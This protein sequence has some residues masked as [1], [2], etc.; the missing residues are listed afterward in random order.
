MRD[1]VLLVARAAT[2]RARQI[3]AVVLVF[4]AGWACGGG[5]SPIAAAPMSTLFEFGGASLDALLAQAGF[6]PI[7]VPFGIVALEAWRSGA[8]LVMTNRGGG[9]GFVREGIDGLLVDPEDEASLAAALV[10]VSADGSLRT[11]LASA[12]RTRVAEFTWAR[13]AHAYEEL[14]AAAQAKADA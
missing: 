5:S 6:P 11:R 13:V 14:Y 2:R 4:S 9:P 7:T 12:G 3:L 10:R 1:T 8:P